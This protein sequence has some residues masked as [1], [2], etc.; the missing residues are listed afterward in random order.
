MVGAVGLALQISVELGNQERAKKERGVIIIW[1]RNPF[2][3]IFAYICVQ[4]KN[5]GRSSLC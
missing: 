5:I 4:L 1:L 3:G 2:L